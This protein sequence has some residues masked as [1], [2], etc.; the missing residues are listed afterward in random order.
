MCLS[1]SCGPGK[2][3]KI[4]VMFFSSDG[5]G[6]ADSDIGFV[7]MP[8]LQH[9]RAIVLSRNDSRLLCLFTHV[10]ADIHTHFFTVPFL[11]VFNLILF[12]PS[13]FVIL[14]IQIQILMVKEHY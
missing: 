13:V 8:R 1:Y 3:V 9:S 2:L 10:N 12:L 6:F 14:Q 7:S 5:D 4:A 11:D